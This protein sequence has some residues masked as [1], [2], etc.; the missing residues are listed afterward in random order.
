MYI[1]RAGMKKR[2]IYRTMDMTDMFSGDVL[3]TRSSGGAGWGNP[4]NRDPERV[5]LNVRDGF[6]SIK[7]ARDVYGVVLTQKD[8]KNPETVAV[9]YEATKKLRSD[10]TATRR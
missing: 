7:R 6:L 8:S 9:D 2:E 4:L 3:V 1:V 5:R 10:M